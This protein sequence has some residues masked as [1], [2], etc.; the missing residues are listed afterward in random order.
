MAKMTNLLDKFQQM[1]DKISLAKKQILAQS[2]E[3]DLDVITI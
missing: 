1:V 2:T 3:M